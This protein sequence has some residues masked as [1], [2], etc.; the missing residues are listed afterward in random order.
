MRV[1]MLNYEYPPLGG[2][3]SNATYYLLKEFSQINDV[4]IDL[5]TSSAINKFEEEKF[6]DDIKIYKL[7]VNK[8]EIHYWTQFEIIK[9][10][11][12]AYF[13]SKKLINQNEYDILHCWFGWPSG[14]IGY[15]FRKRMPYIVALRGSDIPGYNPRLKILDNVIFAQIS[16]IV[17]KNARFVTVLSKDS[18]ELA[19]KTLY[20]VDYKIIRNGINLDKFHYKDKPLNEI[21]ILYVGRFIERKGIK[22]LI[23]AFSELVKNYKNVGLTLVGSGKTYDQIINLSKQ[24]KIYNK[25]DFLGPKEHSELPEI[26]NSHDIFV[27]P[28]LNEALGNVTHE[29]TAS[30]L[31]I[32]TTKTGASELLNQNGLLIEKKSSEDIYNKLNYLIINPELI[33]KMKKR[34]VEI[35]K[36]MTWDK[37]AN[38]YFNLYKTV[39]KKSAKR[40]PTK[41]ENR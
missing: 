14:I 31:V 7:N 9:W 35:S 25:I 5:I 18:M 10:S 33:R 19:K 2:G 15:L 22:Y 32:L 29:A 37:C 20:N 12:R 39:Y 26:Y 28:S 6:S 36:N 30:G 4:T 17:W 21:K 13:L 1:L 8:K 41:S 11:I 38:S 3:A 34:S 27:I 24:L 16:K 40:S 23:E